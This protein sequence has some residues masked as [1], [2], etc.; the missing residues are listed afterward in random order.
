MTTQ[1]TPSRD[2]SRTVLAVL[3][4]GALISS[5]LLIL[6]PFLAPLIWATLLAIASWPALLWVEGRLGNRRGA[7]VAVMMAVLLCVFVIPFLLILGV[8]I[9]QAPSVATWFRD[10]LQ[11]GLPMPP[12]WLANIPVVGSKLAATWTELAAAGPAGLA[13]RVTPYAENLAAWFVSQAGGLGLLMLH[14]LLTL[15]MTSLL[16]AKGDTF[17]RGV[18]RF[19]HRLAGERGERT[20]VLAAKSVRAVAIGVVV[21]ALA[22]SAAGGLGC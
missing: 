21:T 22:Q 6:R 18:L 8:L 17:A 16:F 2:L 14:F 7:A 1:P 11:T 15:V 5:S 20:A 3:C 10:L 9:E 4:I 13:A 19:A 12:A